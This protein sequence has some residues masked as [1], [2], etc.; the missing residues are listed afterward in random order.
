MNDEKK[1]KAQLIKELAELRQQNVELES[2]ETKSQPSGV[3]SSSLSLREIAATIDVIPL[4]A[5]L[6][7]TQEIIVSVNPAFVDYANRRGYGFRKEDRIGHPITTF[8]VT[9]ESRIPLESL[10]HALW[11]QGEPQHCSW[12]SEDEQGTPCY[13]DIHADVLR[14]AEGQIIGALIL[15]EDETERIRQERRKAG[16]ER[17]RNAL[18][19]MS[20]SQDI[21]QVLQVVYQGLKDLCPAIAA[22]SVQVV[23]AEKGDGMSYQISERRVHEIYS[24]PVAGTP[25][26]ECWRE[27]HIIYRPDLKHEDPYG[28]AE[29]IWDETV[30]YSSAVRS[31]LDVPFS[32]GTLAVNSPE[33][34][35]FSQED[36][37][38][39]QEMAK[40]LSEGLTRME[41]LQSLE[42][43][44]REL[45]DKERLLTAFQQMGQIILSSLDR[46][47]IL[48]NLALQ[49][50]QANIFRSLMIALVDEETRTVEVVRSYH[51]ITTEGAITPGRSIKRGKDIEGLTHSLEDENE[52]T[53][54]T[55]RRGELLVHE[56]WGGNLTQEP[57]NPDDQNKVAYFIPIQKQDTVLGVL[58]TASRRDEKEEMLV[59]IDAMEP[60]VDQVAIALEHARFY[61]DIQREITERQQ[62]EGALR[63]SEERFKQ[64]FD[65]AP[66]YCYMISPDG[67][68]MD[69]NKSALKALG[70]EREEI[71]GKPFLATI[72]APSSQEKAKELFQTW[73]KTGQLDNEELEIMTQDGTERTVLLSVDA[74]RDAAGEII[75]SISVQRD[76]T[77]RKQNKEIIQQQNKFLNNVIESLSHPFYVIDANT[78]RIMMAN[79]ATRWGE[80]S[81]DSTCYA[82]T[83]KRNKPCDG[84]EHLCPLKMIKESKKPVLVEH[85]HYDEDGN[86]RDVEIHAYPL[87]GKNGE[88]EKVIEYSMDITERKQM[89][90][91]IRKVHNLESLGLL[92]GGIAHDFNNVLTGVIGNLALLLRLIDKDSEEYEIAMEAKNAADKTEDLTQQLMTFAGGGSPVKETASIEELLRDATELSLH[93]SNTKPVYHFPEGLLSV[94]VDTG[95]IGQVIQNLV[96][97]ADQAMPEGGILKVSAE[98]VEV[99]DEEPL[100]LEAGF[101]VKI[102]IED[103]GIGMSDNILGKIFDPYFSTKQAG[104]GLGLSIVHSIVSRHDGH[105]TVSSEVGVGTTFN[106]YLPASEKQPVTVTEEEPELARG[107]GRILLMD[108]QETIHRTVGRMLKELGYDVDAAYEGTEALQAY[109]EAWAA[110]KPYGVVIMDLTI[111]GG[112]GGEEA[113]VKLHE[114]DPQAR[115]IVAS[116]YSNDPV[117][118]NYADYGFCAMLKKP[119]DL[120][121]LVD[122]VQKVM[123]GSM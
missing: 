114:I 95:Q 89:E 2:S 19:R 119:V 42:Q 1:T 28:E 60:L 80:L 49:V 69:I 83:Y 37:E 55:I 15:R 20:G 31:V 92:A 88:V 106:I 25:V 30:G 78:Y 47:Q 24:G 43:R 38:F 86:A 112:M 68:V 61:K 33:P 36:I 74:V 120:H 6:I 90:E 3:S 91:E 77:E 115:V 16:L 52:L 93:G 122:T 41:D 50:I 101:N 11:Q 81:E 54:R 105:I 76:I 116:G 70:Y 100:P 57:E 12:R 21:H 98:N 66:V 18:W 8:A 103:Q 26:E 14:D 48:D 13:N 123:S 23:D 72:Y 84:R 117:M 44:N 59:K 45:E 27:Q 73:R 32:Q 87:F 35:A 96:L 56:E 22:C 85:V 82:L 5:T 7:D 71:I 75:H 111:P 113:V 34:N 58:A 10:L 121:E 110:D 63:E 29:L 46:E 109:K 62:S 108:D 118:A 104:H 94:D 40:V 4:P 53:V 39:L 64:F 67:K 102:S 17:V 51:C 99:S 9:E 65:H 107:T 97:N 79:S